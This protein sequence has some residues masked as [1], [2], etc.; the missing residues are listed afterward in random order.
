[1]KRDVPE[2]PEYAAE[3][4]LDLDHPTP[5]VRRVWVDEAPGDPGGV[6]LE[7]TD[8]QRVRVPQ[9]LRR[10]VAELVKTARFR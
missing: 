9:K 3:F 8:G 4:A 2:E 7:A 6:W 5:V 1:V 10:C